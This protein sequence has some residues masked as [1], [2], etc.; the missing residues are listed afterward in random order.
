MPKPIQAAATSIAT[1]AS[2]QRNWPG[3]SPI[4]TV[5]GRARTCCTKVFDA[6]AEALAPLYP[7]CEDFLALAARMDPEGRFRNPFVTRL[8]G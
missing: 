2:N 6:D 8:L 5:G 3:G 1:T 7:R 4:A